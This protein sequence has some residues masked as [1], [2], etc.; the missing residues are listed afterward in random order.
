MTGNCLKGSRPIVVFDQQFDEEPHLRLIKEVLSHVSFSTRGAVPE[1]VSCWANCSFA[2]LSTTGRPLRCQ[3]R[4][5]EQN[6]SSTMSSTFPSST[7]R[8]GSATTRYGFPTTM[9]ESKRLTLSSLS[10][11]SPVVLHA[12]ILNTPS[13]DALASTSSSS[14]ALTDSQA[15]NLAKKNNLPHLSLSEVGPRFVLN[16]VKIFEGSFNGACLYENKGQSSI[17]KGGKE[18]ENLRCDKSRRREGQTR[19]RTLTPGPPPAPFHRRVYPLVATVRERETRPRSQ[20]PRTK[21]PASCQSS[22]EGRAARRPEGRP[23]REAE[24]VCLIAFLHLRSLVAPSRFPSALLPQFVGRSARPSGWQWRRCITAREKREL[25]I[26]SPRGGNAPPLRDRVPCMQFL[27][28]Q[29]PYASCIVYCRAGERESVRYRDDLP[30]LS[31]VTAR[32]GIVGITN[33]GEKKTK[34]HADRESSR[35][36]DSEPGR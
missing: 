9:S 15:Q 17:S 27:H 28:F 18:R 11:L 13:A 19:N 21:G 8:S 29:I 14:S 24:R 20:V 1:P 16:P 22:P 36:V 3:R 5:G 23:A 25:Y 12:Q 26:I 32:T 2:L 10:C 7:A 30:S 35:W 6:P 34:E 4:R 31:E 33:T